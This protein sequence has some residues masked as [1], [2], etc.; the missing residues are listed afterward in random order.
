MTILLVRHGETAGNAARVM[1]T[2][3]VPLNERG[4][5]QAEQLAV[6]L[7]ASGFEALVCSDLTRALMTAAP[8][9]ER[10]GVA[11]EESALLEERNFGD[12]R[13]Q[14]YENFAR[15]PFDADFIPPNGESW[16]AFYAR[17]AQAFA[18]VVRR[19]ADLRGPLVVVTHGLVC[20][21]IVERHAQMP[22][23][24]P[25]PAR[26]HNASVTILDAEPPHL[27]RLLN[28]TDHLG[29]AQPPASGAAGA[30][31]EQGESHG[32]A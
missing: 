6:R 23:D 31:E 2:P 18:L 24:L 19:R 12:L 29:A 28:C 27:V 3:D 1:Q 8:V 14:P 22:R 16:E 21:A 9:A 25:V 11:I 15:N 20:H 5:S 13:G 32:A 30:I 17:V 4:R 26:F 7:G 10:A